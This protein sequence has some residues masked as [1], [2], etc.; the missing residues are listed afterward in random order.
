MCDIVF[1]FTAGLRVF[2]SRPVVVWSHLAVFILSAGFLLLE[3]LVQSGLG[4]F[5]RPVTMEISIEVHLLRLQSLGKPSR[6]EVSSAAS[7]TD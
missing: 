5:Q 6:Q 4:I 1:E 3:E 2:G 7:E